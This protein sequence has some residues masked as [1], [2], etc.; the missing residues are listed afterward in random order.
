MSPQ[1]IRTHVVPDGEGQIT[2]VYPHILTKGYGQDYQDD[3]YYESV[4]VRMDGEWTPLDRYKSGEYTIV[5]IPFN[6][7]NI[8]I[9][10]FDGGR[11]NG[12]YLEGR[13]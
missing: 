9:E 2:A 8:L 6:E 1:P 11:C 5:G 3:Y 10:I 13:P 12:F 7:S 4:A